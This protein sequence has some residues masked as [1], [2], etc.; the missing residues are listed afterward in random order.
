M[1]GAS[2][3][4]HFPSGT[5]PSLRGYT[6]TRWT[7]DGDGCTSR[8][9]PT[10]GTTKRSGGALP[11]QRRITPKATAADLHSLSASL[12]GSPAA[13]SACVLRC[14]CYS[15]RPP[16]P[17]DSDIV[18]VQCAMLPSRFQPCKTHQCSATG[19]SSK[20]SLLARKLDRLINGTHSFGTR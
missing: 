19:E 13:V 4:A 3:S 11:V 1:G 20:Y 5:G 8:S 16:A 14:I 17:R 12:R 2:R 15:V 10:E 6:C 18:T 9:H 7:P